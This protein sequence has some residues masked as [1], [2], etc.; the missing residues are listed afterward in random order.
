[1]LSVIIPV[2]NEKNTILE[3]IKKIETNKIKKEIIIVDDCSTDGTREILQNITNHNYKILFHDKN[4][5]KGAAIKSAKEKIN[6]DIIVIQDADLE[7]NPNDYYKLIEPIFL[8]EVEVVYGSRVLGSNRYLMQN[9]SSVY[10]IFFNHM[11]TI[12]SN[13]IN[14]QNLTDAHTCYKTFSSKVFN[15]ID[16]EENDFS[17]C[18]EITTKIALKKIK[19]KEVKIDYNG[20]SYKEGK[21]IKLSDGIKAIKTL[22]K[23]RYLKR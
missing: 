4:L 5:G 15:S 8:N 3:I 18:P 11:L 13:F 20:R 22:F 14:K 9:F 17:F 16:L 12:L 19:I 23:Y 2:Y 10:R 1:M 7:Y 21:K 6:G